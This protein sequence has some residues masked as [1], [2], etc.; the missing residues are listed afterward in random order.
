[1]KRSNEALLRELK[2]LFLHLADAC[3][4]GADLPSHLVEA[5]NMALKNPA[6]AQFYRESI[7]ANDWKLG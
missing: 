6:V 2:E 1:M 7:A 3:D 4:G 5:Y